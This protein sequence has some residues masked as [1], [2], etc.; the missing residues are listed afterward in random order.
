[1]HEVNQ[2][3]IVLIPKKDHPQTFSDFRPISLCNVVYKL[4]TKVIANKLKLVMAKLILPNQ[5]S[6]VPGRHITDNILITQE[7]LHP[8]TFVRVVCHGWR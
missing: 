1:M 5:S 2:T 4:V 7:V 8:C 6:F 3:M